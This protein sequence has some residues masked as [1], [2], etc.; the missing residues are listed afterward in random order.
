MVDSAPQPPA[1]DKPANNASSG[2]S[3]NS[4]EKPPP[5]T[6][7]DEVIKERTAV[8]EYRE[9]ITAIYKEK[10]PEKVAEVDNFL[11][12]YQGQE[13]IL[14][15]KIC[16]KYSVV[17]QPEYRG[18]CPFGKGLNG[19][20]SAI[21]SAL[22][23]E[24]KMP[25]GSSIPGGTSS[26]ADSSKLGNATSTDSWLAS[27]GDKTEK[28]IPPVAAAAPPA[29]AAASDAPAP[30]EP[31]SAATGPPTPS[32]SLS[33]GPLGS[34]KQTLMGSS[35]SPPVSNQPNK[36]VASFPGGKAVSLAASQTFSP[37]ARAQEK[38]PNGSNGK[39]RSRSPPP[40]KVSFLGSL[41]D[42]GSR[43]GNVPASVAT[44]AASTSQGTSTT[45]WAVIFRGELRGALSQF[46]AKTVVVCSSK[47][48]AMAAA[49]KDMM[50][51]KAEISTTGKVDDVVDGSASS[52]GEFACGFRIKYTGDPSGEKDGICE[53]YL[54]SH[55][56][57]LR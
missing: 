55:P 4:E 32:F 1:E 43:A 2:G 27:L 40:S 39:D 28:K 12:K 37:L 5:P 47:E 46:E 34:M 49:Q 56:L 15:L 35:L 25:F 19:I 11:K 53:W 41:A 38:G 31:P 3:G 23:G 36:P 6:I 21:P 20:K 9:R 54:T 52:S 13:H 22:P 30:S 45:V 26:S 50:S 18:N 24:L 8:E 44:G 7:M 29:P 33:S 17:A 48:I 16:K 42:A 10:Q 57:L 14:Y 51:R